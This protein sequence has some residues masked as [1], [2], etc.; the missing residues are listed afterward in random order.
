LLGLAFDA[1]AADST[2]I[3]N[4]KTQNANRT[5]RYFG[6]YEL[7]EEIARGGMGV[8]YRARQLSLNRPV[9]LKMILTGRL[10]TPASMQ[11][12]H[13][14]AEA[15]ARLD[16]ANIVPIYEIGE[17]DGQHYFSMKLIPGGT[18]ANAS[19]RADVQSRRSVGKAARLVSTV[20][21]AVH[22]AHQ[23]GI[24]HRDLKPTNILLDEQGEPHVTDFGLAKL[25]EDDSSLTL[26]TAVLGTPAYMSPEQAAGQS[27]GLTTTADIYSLGAVLYELLTGC[28]P[29]LPQT[30]VETLRQVCEQEPTRL[31]TLNPAV[32]RDLETICLKCLSKDPQRRYGSAEMLADDLDRWRKSEPIHARPV[33]SVEKLWSWCRRKPAF[34]TVLALVILLLLVVGIG[35]PIA[36]LRI[37]RDRRQTAHLLYVANMNVAQQVWEENNISRL[38]LLLQETRDSADRGFEWYYWQR[39]T[40]LAQKT[41]SGAMMG[42]I[43]VAFSP[44]GQRIFGCTL[45]HTAAAKVWDTASGRELFALRPQGPLTGPAGFSCDGRL[46]AFAS[47]NGSANV[48]DASSSREILNLNGHADAIVWIA[49]SSDAHWIGTASRD[50]TAMVW[51]ASTGLRAHTLKGHRGPVMAVAFSP[52]ARRI[53]TGGYD[54]LVKVWDAANGLELF[55]LPGHTDYVCTVAFA[56]DGR[57]IVSGGRDQKVIVWDVAERRA[58]LTLEH[59]LTVD[60]AAFSQDGKRIVTGSEDQIAKVWD[61]VS[62]RELFTLKGHYAAV[63]SVAFS[64]DGQRIVSGSMDRTVR[65]WDSHGTQE[66]L[67]LRGHTNEIWSVAVS[68]NSKWIVTGSRDQTARVWEAASGRELV[69]LKGHSDGVFSVAFSPD[70]QRIV[71]GSGDNTAKVWDAVN[72]N[73]MR[74]FNGHTGSIPAVAFSPNG[75]RIVTGS[76]DLTAK[77]WEV[78]SDKPLF[79]LKGHTDGINSVSFSPDGSRIV[80]GS[81]DNTAKIWDAANGR[82]LFPLKGH[83]DGVFSVAFSPDG[84]RIVTGSG[85]NTAKVWDAA[86]GR[87]LLELKG[88]NASIASV[89]VSPDGKRILTGGWD[90]TA[91]LWDA[92]SGR[93]VL[94]LKRHSGPVLS[95][96]FSSDGQ[97]IVTGSYDQT[98][99]VWQAAQPEQVAAWQEEERAATQ[100]L[101][102]FLATG[103]Q[104]KRTDGQ[105]RSV[106]R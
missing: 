10:A 106:R 99:K 52:D 89:A 71:T 95:I 8:V 102:V 28:P 83:S 67:T 66:P 45:E 69:R 37:N 92:A 62:G 55:S 64:A 56:P 50:Q 49:F 6:D 105:P 51:D 47:T 2:P 27:K 91:K 20:A 34:A 58:V 94:T 61:A 85:D 33:N 88:H 39:Q 59:G 36:A 29:F 19:L 14:E 21:R 103:S 13:T 26:S 80:T 5:I 41:I 65:V 97:W 96:V 40:H 68:P 90:R 7:F 42:A 101:E 104:S 53:V 32:D 23:R 18:L 30:T 93:E 87:E 1:S 76:Y 46:I 82:E 74:T 17:H 84:Q 57:R 60:A 86:T 11:R 100:K 48:Y 63:T 24:L 15:A 22:Y 79:T 73:A 43:S 98:A 25:A 77:V 3:A 4:R 9:A 78:N 44:D 75:R 70:G 35:S 16:H 72:G 12:F 38:R 54:K 81:L 31:H